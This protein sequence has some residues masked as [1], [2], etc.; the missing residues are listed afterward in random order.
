MRK[1][2]TDATAFLPSYDQRQCELVSNAIRMAQEDA[3]SCS[4][5]KMREI[6]G[7]IERLRA[8]AAPK[9][10]FAF[11]RKV[12]QSTASSPSKGAT[13]PSTPQPDSTASPQSIAASAGVVLSGRSHEFLDLSSLPSSVLATDLIVSDLDHCI[14]YMLPQA[15][16]QDDPAGRVIRI[17]ALHMRNVRN[18]VL[19]LPSIQ[20]SALLH[21]LSR[22]VLALGCH[23]VR[24][25]KTLYSIRADDVFFSIACTPQPRLTCTY[26]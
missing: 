17:T 10:K 23:Q 26:L 16:S 14:V 18:S 12:N 13:E 15:R 25:R 8:T 3:R 9:P 20:G 11:K 2:L 24:N 7:S 19:I 1:E 6:E 21:D 4:A 22:C 5:Q